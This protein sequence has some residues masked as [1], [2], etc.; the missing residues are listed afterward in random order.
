MPAGG[1]VAAGETP[2]TGEPA[3]PALPVVAPVAPVVVVRETPAPISAP[4][5]TP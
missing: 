5:L 1:V 2:L 4:G 3:A